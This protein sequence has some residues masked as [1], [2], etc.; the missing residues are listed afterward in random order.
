MVRYERMVVKNVAKVPL[1][2]KFRNCRLGRTY[3]I[4]I[5]KVPLFRASVDP[6]CNYTVVC[7]YITDTAGYQS[8]TLLWL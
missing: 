3:S 6:F 4:H 2:I 8:D 1:G 5:S 7:I